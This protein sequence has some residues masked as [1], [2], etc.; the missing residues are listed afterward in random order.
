M[1]IAAPPAPAHARPRSIIDHLYDPRS[2]GIIFQILLL[3]GL[4]WF[5]YEII[6]NAITNL[7]KQ[8]IASG[9]DFLGYTSGFD[10]SQTLIDY[11]NT[12]TYGR[13]F[14]VGLLNTLLVAGL[15]IVLATI[16]GFLVGIARLSNNWIISKLAMVYVEVLRNIPPLLM[17]FAVYFAA[18]KTLPAPKDSITLPFSSFLNV[19]GLSVPKPIWGDGISFVVIAFLVAVVGAVLLARWARQRQEATGE[20]FPAVLAGLGLVAGLPLLAFAAAGF[21]V[22]FEMPVAGRFNIAGGLTLLPEFVAL[23]VG[24][25]LYTAAFIAEIV[26]SGIMGVSKGQK[27][28]AAALGLTPGQSMRLVVIPQAL[29]II[30]PPLTN[31]YLNL[32]KNSSLAVAIG[33]PDLGSVFAGTVLNQTYQA[34]EVILFTMGVYLTV[35]L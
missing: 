28:A 8:S 12:S 32:T 24:L 1:T 11:T 30:I 26:R 31:Q 34:I 19:R 25:T 35:S 5:G 21:P 4:V 22:S 6:N 7:K 29:R 15:G 23:L 2:R 18:L 13:A 16:I 9:F 20:R 3:V 27:E 33:Y 14:W 17:L 10:I